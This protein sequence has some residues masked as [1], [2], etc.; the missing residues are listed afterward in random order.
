[1]DSMEIVQAY[2]SGALEAG[3][4]EAALKERLSDTKTLA[5]LREA[6][7]ARCAMGLLR[8]S[9]QFRRGELSPQDMCLHLRDAILFLGRL[10]VP[11]TLYRLAKSHGKPYGLVCEPDFVLSCLRMVPDWL[12]HSAYVEDVYALRPGEGTELE[13][14]SPGDA[15][16]TEHTR[17]SRYKSFEQKLAVHTACRLPGGYTLLISQPTGGGKSLITQLLA[18]TTDGLTLVIVPTVALAL[19]QYYGAQQNLRLQEGIYCYRGAQT[20]D[21]RKGLIHALRQKRAR[22]LFASPEAIFKNEELTSLLEEAGKEGYLCNVV[23]DEAHVVPDWGVFFRPDFQIF[24]VALRKWRAQS[25]Q[26]LRTYLLSATL[27]DDV[28]ESLLTLFGAPG[29]NVQLRCDALRQEPRFY[30]HPAKTREEQTRS[31]LEAIRLLPKPMVVYVLEPREAALLQGR[32]REL[33]YRNIPVFTGETGEA[34]RDRILTGWKEQRWDVVIATSAF[35]IGVDKPDVRT[36]IH[37]CVPENVSRYYQEVGRGGR[38]HLPS[39]SVL[40]PYRSNTDGGSDIHRA[41]GLVNKRVLTVA[42]MVSRWYGMLQSPRAQIDADRCVLDTSATPPTMT[43]EEAEYAGNRNSAWNINLLLFLHRAGFIDLLDVRYDGASQ[44]YRMTAKLLKLDVLNDP[45]RLEAALEEP[46]RQELER[47]LKGYA[48]MRDLVQR[49]EA[50]CWG[51]VFQQLFP[52]AQEV[53]SGCPVDR[54]GRST[55]DAAY[56]LRLPPDLALPPVPPGRRLDRLMGSY[57]WLIVSRAGMGEVSREELRLAAEKAS[58]CGVGALVVPGRLADGLPFRGLVLT[59]EEFYFAAATTPY[60]FAGG[61]LCVFGT[62]GQTNQTLY[63]K[64]QT[65]EKRRYRCLLY[66]NESMP[67]TGAGRAVCEDVDGYTVA[68]ERL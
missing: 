27:S 15:L 26:R 4:A 60:L 30:F 64:L 62:D 11:E 14:S 65:L 17:F 2:L 49:P 28:V 18:S 33:G 54:N 47:Q 59:Y 58:A 46:R 8:R 6:A 24:S 36:V 12:P 50:L 63:R 67:V 40:L 41:W 25:C 9:A 57:N 10:Q 39:L 31:V 56:K 22:L 19:D 3:R 55:T 20:A 52:L 61:V 45:E 37:A 7:R 38:D 51:R 21:A 13:E 44:S 32:L 16:L 1:M 42:K 5:G 35:G 66:C 29:R 68:L 48:V 53:C 34:E 43:A 23:V